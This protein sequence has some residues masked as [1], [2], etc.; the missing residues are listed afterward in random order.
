MRKLYFFLAHHRSHFSIVLALS[1]S[2]FLLFSNDSPNIAA[3]RAKA[4][5]FFVAVYSPVARIKSLVYLE[6]T[7]SLLRQ[8]N[9]QYA[10]QLEAS[11]GLIEENR[12][13][14][15]MLTF[16]RENPLELVPARI[17]GKGMTSNLQSVM[18]NVGKDR[19][20]TKNCPVITPEGVIGKTVLVSENTSIVQLISDMSFRLS[21]RI[22]PGGTSGI[23]RWKNSEFCEVNEV[24][25]NAEVNI[26]DRVVTSGYSDIFPADMPVGIV[27]GVSDQRGQY[28][29]TVL[30]DINN[31][32]GSLLNV[33]VIRK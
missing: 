27:K 13:L 9:L 19:G 17:V 8:K 14:R 31:D 26:G 18:L 32:L 33:F 23:L 12:Q 21:V 10:L 3:L 16:A 7:N 1:I 24:M 2:V 15:E 30:V 20:L 28:Q 25:K 5:E 11:R 29:K 22:L 4:S 6:E